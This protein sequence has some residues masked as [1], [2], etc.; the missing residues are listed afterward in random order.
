MSTMTAGRKRILFWSPEEEQPGL[1]ASTKGRRRKKAI[2]NVCKV[3]LRYFEMSYRW[4]LFRYIRYCSKMC[5]QFNILDSILIFVPNHLEP[6]W[7]IDSWAPT[8]VRSPAVRGLTVWESNCPGVQLSIFQR[9]PRGPASLLSRSFN[10]SLS[11]STSA[12]LLGRLWSW[13]RAAHE[14]VVMINIKMCFLAMIFRKGA[15]RFLRES[16]AKIKGNV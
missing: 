15:G 7:K 6:P 10:L 14:A 3:K 12:F 1:L 11:Q 16:F 13:W 4:V 8:S 5:A 9:W 2:F